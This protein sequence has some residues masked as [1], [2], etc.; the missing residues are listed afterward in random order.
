M[1]IKLLLRNPTGVFQ[2]CGQKQGRVIDN[3]KP[4]RRLT[5]TV[6]RCGRFSPF[7]NPMIERWLISGLLVG[8]R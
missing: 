1:V 8:R 6:K 5:M 4:V 7:V 2:C 3:G